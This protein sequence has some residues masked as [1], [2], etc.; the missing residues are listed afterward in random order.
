MQDKSFCVVIPVFNEENGIELFVNNLYSFLS[1]NFP[2]RSTITLINDNSTD[3]SLSILENFK[4]SNESLDSLSICDIIIHTS[5]I[6]RGYGNAIKEAINFDYEK[7]HDF[8]IIMD[9]DG[10]NPIKDIAKIYERVQLGSRYVKANRYFLNSN[11]GKSFGSIQ[12]SILSKIAH[13]VIN[14]ILKSE[15]LDPSNGFRAIGSE[16]KSIVLQNSSGFSSIIEEWVRIEE[17][18]IK[19]SNFN[20][21]LGSRG[22]NQRKSSFNYSISTMLQYLK[23]ILFLLLRRFRSRFGS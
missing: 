1:A 17:M 8:Y 18:G 13:K 16:F 22:T 23:P 3:G 12:R 6:S 11:F 19:I 9:S 20:S 15:C 10:T 21:E 5:S 4:H 7:D 14:I 2:Y